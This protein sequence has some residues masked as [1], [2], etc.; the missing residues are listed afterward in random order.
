MLTL[1]AGAFPI[2]TAD[3]H[4]LFLKQAFRMNHDLEV[5]RFSFPSANSREPDIQLFPL[6]D[7][8]AYLRFTPSYRISSGSPEFQFRFWSASS[9]QD[10]TLFIEP[11]IVNSTYGTE[12]LGADYS[13][14]DM[15]GRIANSFLRYENNLINIQFGRSPVWWGQA[16]ESSIIQSGHFPA[17]D[18][19]SARLNI[20]NF[21]MELLSGQLSSEYIS[22]TRI[23]RYIAGHRINWFSKDSHWIVSL[24][25]QIIY[26]GEDRSLELFYLNPAIPYF[27]TALEGDETTAPDND[28]SIIFINGRY[29]FK[30]NLSAYFEFIIDEYQVDKNTFPHALGYKLG[31]DGGMLVS[32]NEDYVKKARFLSTQA[33]EPEIHYEHTELGYNY[34]MSNLLAAVGRGQLEVIEDRVKARRLIFNRYKKA[35]S[36]IDGFTFMQE[37]DYGKS[38]RWLTTLTVDEKCAGISRTQIIDALEKENIEARP[39]WKPMHMQPFYNECEYVTAGDEDIAKNLFEDGL[40]L[41]SGSSLSVSDQNRIIDIIL[42]VIPT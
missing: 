8:Q 21:Q 3:P 34:R 33:R 25:E 27:I 9:W 26:T 15:S 11:V 6:A 19:L 5:Y 2:S 38:N 35:L 14:S 17:Y 1:Q 20:G 4:Y 13:R 7:S 36:H 23:K 42:E 22:N 31:L 12:Y 10:F 18:H 32:N 37:A 28:N 39:V 30:P 41:P 24:G 40:C 29:L 16:W